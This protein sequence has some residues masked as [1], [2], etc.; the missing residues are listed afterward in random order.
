MILRRAR[1]PALPAHR[2][3]HEEHQRDEAGRGVD[4]LGKVDRGV[5]LRD[6]LLQRRLHPA[7]C[8][9]VEEPV[10]IARP[11]R[12][13]RDAIWVRTTGIVNLVAVEGGVPVRFALNVEHSV[14]HLLIERT[15]GVRPSRARARRRSTKQHVVVIGGDERR[16][17]RV[18]KPEEDRRDLE[19]A[20]DLCRRRPRTRGL[21]EWRAARDRRG[22]LGETSCGA[23]AC[24]QRADLAAFLAPHAI[25]PEVKSRDFPTRMPLILRDGDMRRQR[26]QQGCHAQE[27][28]KGWHHQE[29]PEAT[30]YRLASSAI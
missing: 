20:A 9:I 30:A 26:A 5:Q 18:F 22:E 19:H 21:T 7:D 4:V 27:S 15:V 11:E 24:A 14:R 13:P 2:L 10:T 6:R 25:P 17:G 8:D 12:I 28:D 23:Q 3:V 16:R 1:R 29:P